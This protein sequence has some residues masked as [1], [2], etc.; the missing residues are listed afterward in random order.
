MQ[1]N[2]LPQFFSSYGINHFK[3]DMPLQLALR[4][5]GLSEH[6]WE[7]L[8][9]LGEY[10]GRDLLE[11]VDYID[12]T[13][14]PLLH[15]WD[16]VGNR[17]DWV[18]LNPAHRQ[19]L[20]NLMSRG[21]VYRTFREKD[22]WQVH[23]AMGYLIA[24][25]GVYCT[26]T[27]TQQTAYALYKYADSSLLEKFLPHYL[28][29]DGKKA[30]YGAT[31]YTEVQGGSDLGAN[32]AVARKVGD[33]WVIDSPD[34]YFA[35]NAGIADAALI[36]ARPE[37]NPPGA[38]GIALFFVPALREDGSPNY[39]LRRLKDKLATR[40]VPSSELEMNTSEAYLLG[41]IEHGIYQAL[42]VLTVARLANS[43]AA[44]GIARKAYL[45]AYHFVQKR[46][47]FGKRLIEHPLIQ[48]DLLEM[49][50]E[51]EANLILL[52]KAIEAF[53]D[54]WESRPPYDA[55]YFY[56]RLLTHLVKNISAEM[57]ARVTQ[58]ALELHGGNGFIE[59][60]PVARWHR[61]ALVL[62]IWEG[63]SNIQALD[64]LEVIIKKQAHEMLFSKLESTLAQLPGSSLTA[65]VGA[66]LTSVK[67][68]IPEII[69]SGASDMQ[70]AAKDLL[71]ELGTCA[72]AVFLLEAAEKM[73]TENTDHRF[74]KVAELY[75]RKFIERKPL[76]IELIKG[77]LPVIQIEKPVAH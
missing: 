65:T 61:E 50:V 9:D 10:V 71:I 36:T 41:K 43:A 13:S 6:Y 14:R 3:V 30:W 24:D 46:S 58:L 23:F 4:Y 26:I 31:F 12:R 72:S 27:V 56:A 39:H 33:H 75:I 17:I 53:D 47:A 55:D 68:R 48:K 67:N 69:A 63:G 45:E 44:A 32:R 42:E 60:F 57:S 29:Q 64:M 70:Y 1:K 38:K 11:I 62:P 16:I 74:R 2:Y 18:R 28:T 52:V 51:I 25:P 22:P 7:H 34:K 40:A 66:Y 15:Q 20:E 8:E 5:A 73:Q 59:D 19:M 76:S 54:C 35:S 37:G 21:I 49:E 77:A